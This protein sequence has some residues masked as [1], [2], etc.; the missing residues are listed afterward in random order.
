MIRIKDKEI[1]KEDLVKL[2]KT[3]SVKEI[4]KIFNCEVD[5]MYYHLRNNK[6]MPMPELKKH[7]NNFPKGWLSRSMG[8]NLNPY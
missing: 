8:V 5:T 6:I 4:S 7:K 2:F 3:R 1:S